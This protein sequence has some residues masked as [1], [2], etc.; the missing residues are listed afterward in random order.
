[1]S[2]TNVALQYVGM[3]KEL[4]YAFFLPYQKE[5]GF[6]L[7]FQFVHVGNFHCETGYDFF[8]G[9]SNYYFSLT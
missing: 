3:K 1:M 9:F 6:F 5:T 7:S 8:L 4:S 2:N